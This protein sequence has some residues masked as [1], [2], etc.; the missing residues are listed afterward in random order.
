MLQEI[1]SDR[2]RYNLCPLNKNSFIVFV[3]N[4]SGLLLKTHFWAFCP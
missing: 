3:K 4:Y 2:R 1:Y